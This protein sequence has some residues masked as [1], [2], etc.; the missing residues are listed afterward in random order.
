VAKTTIPRVR[1]AEAIRTILDSSE[2]SALIDDLQETRW[3]GRPGYPIRAMVGMAMVKAYY[4]LPTWTRTA[5]LVREHKALRDVLGAAPSID[6][7]YRFTVKLR[8][9]SDLL[10]SCIERVLSALHDEMPEMGA[11]VAIDGSD[12]PAYANGQRFLRKGGPEREKFSDPDASWGHRSAVS[13]RKGGGYYGYKVHAAVCTTTGLPVAWQVETARDSEL[14]LVP[15]LLDK[16]AASGFRPDYAVLDKGYDAAAIY[17]TCESRGIRPIVPLCKTGKVKA[18]EHLPPEC[19]HGTWTFA[20]SDAKRG[21]SKWRCPTGECKPASKWVKASRL[22]TL[23]PRGTER[24]KNLYHQRASVER[25]FGR[26]KHEFGALPLRVRRL[27]RVALHVNLT[28]LA[29]LAL[30]LSATRAAT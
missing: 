27:E 4:A 12:L 24:W 17:E 11:T 9:H 6:A 18:G 29:Q 10:A 14:P 5:A 2:V 30:A 1:D 7:C 13:V 16:L 8:D 26:L 22:H 23:I 25:C 15:T 3:T 19:E 21:A 28:I 20:G